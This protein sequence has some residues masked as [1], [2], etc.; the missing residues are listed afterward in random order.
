[1]QLTFAPMYPK[2]MPSPEKQK[3][4]E[5][6]KTRE[7]ARAMMRIQFNCQQTHDSDLEEDA[8]QFTFK[9]VSPTQTVQEAIEEIRTKEIVRRKIGKGG[10]MML[11]IQSGGETVKIKQGTEDA[12]TYTMQNLD[13]YTPKEGQQHGAIK[14]RIWGKTG[15]ARG[16]ADGGS[17]TKRGRTEAY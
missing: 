14:A 10:K 16:K 8:D 17:P 7:K 2:E 12:E 13:G 4:K 3:A 5:A 15:A 11:E 9:V 6:A 1:M